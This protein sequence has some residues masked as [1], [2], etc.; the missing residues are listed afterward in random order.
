[1]GTRLSYYIEHNQSVLDYKDGDSFLDAGCG[2]GQNIKEL[3]CRYPHSKIKGFD[4]NRGALRVIATA[5]KNRTNV[6]VEVGSVVGQVYME[7]F[8]ANAVDHV[9]V[10]HV[11]SFLI[12]KDLEETKKLRQATVDQLL[13]VAKKTVV[14]LDANIWKEDEG[15][16]L[17]IEQNTRCFISESLAPYFPA[18]L[19]SGEF[20]LTL[21]P[22]DQAFIFKMNPVP[23]AR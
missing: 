4:V 7:E 5:L 3:A 20:Y 13:R 17:V 15:I 16:E 14:I 10:S 21:A 9:V 23:E 22:E 11:F 8:P 18:S 1:M 12:G 2:R 19:D 6:L